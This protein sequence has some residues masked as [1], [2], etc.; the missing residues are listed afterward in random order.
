MS[1]NDLIFKKYNFQEAKNNLDELSSKLMVNYQINLPEDF[2]NYLKNYENFEGF[3]N[4]EFIS[5]WPLDELIEA[6]E[7]NYIFEIE[8]KTIG[9]G[10]NGGGEL[11]ALQ[12]E[13]DV[14]KVV[15]M[16]L[17]GLDYPIKIGT[18]FSNFLEKLDSGEKFL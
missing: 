15:L 14:W 2:I 1:K 18:S 13:D 3:I 4:N 5:L 11:I 17:I 12:K 10:T 8:P 16:P 7:L 9:I 6:N